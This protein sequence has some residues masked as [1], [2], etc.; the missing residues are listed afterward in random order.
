[1]KYTA[2]AMALTVAVAAAL[3]VQADR[4]QLKSAAIGLV[5]AGVACIAAFIVLNP[6]AIF[7]FHEVRGQ[8]AGQSGQAGTGKLG[9]DDTYG[10][11]YYLG[12][13]GWGLGWLPFVAAIA[14]GVLVLVRDRRRGV[15]LIPFPVFLY[16]FLGS[17]GRFFGRWMLPIYPV[18]AILAGYAVV[19]AA[20]ALGR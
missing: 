4:T 19:E 6:W 15:L 7:D 20:R 14:G 8:V 10:W 11:F 17:Q 12:T 1:T 13:F 9:Q 18:L 5:L 16:L 2:G 3:R